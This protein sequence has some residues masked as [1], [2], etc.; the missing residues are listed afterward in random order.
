MADNSS[1]VEELGE[2]SSSSSITIGAAITRG[3]ERR[4]KATIKPLVTPPCPT[5]GMSPDRFQV[6]Q[7]SD[8]SLA[9]QREWAETGRIRTSKWDSEMFVRKKDL[10]YRELIDKKGIN[11]TQLVVPRITEKKS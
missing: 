8:P 10:L 9:Q 3:M 11:T 1:L 7:Q 4:E 6:S 5:T 2:N